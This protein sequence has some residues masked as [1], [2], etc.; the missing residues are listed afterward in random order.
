MGA[1]VVVEP[2]TVEV[3]VDVSVI[4]EVIMEVC[5]VVEDFT[6]VEV[7]VAVDVTVAE[8]VAVAMPEVRV[9]LVDP[10]SV[11][12]AV[13][14]VFVLVIITVLRGGILRRLEQKAEPTAEY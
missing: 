7:T 12:D 6:A 4:V 10:V 3:E 2:E 13:T 1:Y 9:E 14:V 11:D 5:E 8:L